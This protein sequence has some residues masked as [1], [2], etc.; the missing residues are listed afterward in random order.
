MNDD[1]KHFVMGRLSQPVTFGLLSIQDLVELADN[2]CSA[3][4]H[5]LEE[6][7]SDVAPVINAFIVYLFQYIPGFIDGFIYR[8]SK[9]SDTKHPAPIGENGA[10]VKA[11]ARMKDQAVGNGE[12]VGQDR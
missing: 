12:E 2:H 3:L 11:G 7:V 1:E 6:F 9:G 4:G 8:F 10:V 5:C